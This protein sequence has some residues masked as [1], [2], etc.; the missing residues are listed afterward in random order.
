MSNRRGRRAVEPDLPQIDDEIE[1]AANV[2]RVVRSPP[3]IP[4]PQAPPPAYHQAVNPPPPIVGEDPNIHNALIQLLQQQ[5]RFTH[6][7]AQIQRVAH[8]EL[9]A[10]IRGFNA[11]QVPPVHRFGNI[12]RLEQQRPADRLNIHGRPMHNVPVWP[13]NANPQNIFMD[14]NDANGNPQGNARAN[15]WKP[16]N[17]VAESTQPSSA[18]SSILAQPSSQSPRLHMASVDPFSYFHTPRK[19]VK[20]QS[21]TAS[22][23]RRSTSPVRGNERPSRSNDR[24]T[25]PERKCYVCGSADHIAPSCPRR[26][27]RP[28]SSA[29]QGP[30]SSVNLAHPSDD[31]NLTVEDIWKHGEAKQGIEHSSYEKHSFANKLSTIRNLARN[32]IEVAQSKY[33]HYYNQNTKPHNYETKAVPPQVQTRRYMPTPGYFPPP[34]FYYPMM[35]PGMMQAMPPIWPPM[36]HQSPR[37]KTPSQLARI[38]RRTANYKA[39]QATKEHTTKKPSASASTDTSNKQEDIKIS[40]SARTFAD[41]MTQTDDIFILKNYQNVIPQDCNSQVMNNTKILGSPASNTLSKNPGTERK[42]RAEKKELELSSAMKGTH[43]STI[44]LKQSVSRSPNDFEPSDFSRPLTPDIPS[45]SQST[46]DF[47]DEILMDTD[48]NAL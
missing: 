7:Q 9:L 24:T 39:R 26:S 1:A 47:E 20:F 23:T 33:L 13:I 12:R 21:P 31:E 16:I 19:E 34:P 17:K 43:I 25:S 28:Q 37:V 45:K 32:E 46:N 36:S 29:R 2:Q 4:P 38:Q 35:N 41:A 3:P 30:S 8:E 22:P 40:A 18:E 42:K 14:A 5:Q 10:A 15:A 27:P 11:N 44:N 6:E 48:D